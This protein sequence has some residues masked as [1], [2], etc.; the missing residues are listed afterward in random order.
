M[1]VF[2]L[3][4]YKEFIKTQSYARKIK[5]DF[6]NTVGSVTVFNGIFIQSNTTWSFMID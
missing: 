2:A 1:V 6:R 3:C 5:S 4:G